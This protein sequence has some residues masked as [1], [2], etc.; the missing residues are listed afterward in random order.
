MLK[1]SMNNFDELEEVALSWIN[2]LNAFT[3]L[4]WVFER[5]RTDFIL[6]DS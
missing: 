3:W 5:T 6:L 2:I 4:S 1:S